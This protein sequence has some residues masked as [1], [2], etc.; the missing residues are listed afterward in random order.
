MTSSNTENEIAKLDPYG[1]DYGIFA[2]AL[3]R[4]DGLTAEKLKA[5]P[6]T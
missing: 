2:E 4:F 6:G 1:P 3:R 5:G